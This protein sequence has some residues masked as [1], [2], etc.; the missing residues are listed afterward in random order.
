[1]KGVM[2]FGNKGKL[3]TRY[4]SPYEVL[5]GVG[6]FLYDLKLHSKLDSAHPVLHVCML[7]KCIGDP[8]SI[9]PVEGLGVY[10]N[11]SYE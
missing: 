7:K 8:V 9:P 6:K 10:K 5:Q 1:M 4:V 3:G 11:L 2:R